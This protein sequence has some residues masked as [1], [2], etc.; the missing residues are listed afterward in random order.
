MLHY[1]SIPKA[2]EQVAHGM[3]QSVQAFNSFLMLAQGHDFENAARAQ[4][5]ASSALESAMDAFMDA[6]RFHSQMMG[7]DDA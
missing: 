4:L 1:A 7:G 6:C 2:L 3:S 5:M